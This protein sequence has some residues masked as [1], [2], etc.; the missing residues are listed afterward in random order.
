MNDIFTAEQISHALESRLNSNLTFENDAEKEVKRLKQELAL[1]R[2]QHTRC[3][4]TP[5]R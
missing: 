3:R 2:R 5:L 4:E 1:A